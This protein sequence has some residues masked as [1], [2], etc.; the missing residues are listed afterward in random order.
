MLIPS[1][2]K[3]LNYNEVGAVLFMPTFYQLHFLLLKYLSRTAAG[4]G[5]DWTSVKSDPDLL[6]ASA[7]PGFQKQTFGFWWAGG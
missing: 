6:I 5:L 1:Y 2:L 7:D 4:R 3:L